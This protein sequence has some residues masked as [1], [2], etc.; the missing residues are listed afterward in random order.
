MINKCF[1]WESQEV[2]SALELE[3]LGSEVETG[4]N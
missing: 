2:L 1:I 4:I 3:N